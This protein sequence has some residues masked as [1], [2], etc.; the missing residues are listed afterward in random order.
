MNILGVHFI[1]ALYDFH[2]LANIVQV[3][4]LTVLYLLMKFVT[5]FFLYLSNI[6]NKI[7]IMIYIAN[8]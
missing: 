4:L 8:K 7:K 6:R 5:Y 1:Y 2:V 3:T